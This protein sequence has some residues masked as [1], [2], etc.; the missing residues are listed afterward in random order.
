MLRLQS[1]FASFE[2][3][4]SL[5]AFAATQFFE[6]DLEERATSFLIEIQNL[7]LLFMRSDMSQDNMIAFECT[8]CHNINY[9][10]R[11]NK[12]TLKGAS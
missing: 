7:C 8:E 5:I 1:Y 9:H 2:K 3:L 11:K 10:S 4:F 6:E 12:K